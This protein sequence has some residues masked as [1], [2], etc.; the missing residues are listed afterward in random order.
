MR[1]VQYLIIDSDFVQGTNNN[2]VVTFGITSNTFIQEMKDVVAIKLVD[3]YVTQV[4]V[5]GSGGHG[6]GA[7]YIDI[8]CKDIPTA[9]QMLSE[10]T[11]EVFARVPLERDSDGGANYLV[12]DKEWKPYTND[13]RYFN[14][15][16]IKSLHFQMFEYQGDGDYLPLHPGAEFYMVLELT[17]IDHKAPPEDKLVTV[18][19]NLE[20]I[21]EKLDNMTRLMLLPPPEPPQKKYPVKYLVLIVVL[22]ALLV[23]FIRRSYRTSSVPGQ[24]RPGL[25]V[26]VRPGM[27]AGPQGPAPA[28]ALAP[29]VPLG[30]RV[31][32]PLGS[33]FAM[34][35]RGL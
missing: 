9:G 19:E 3:F 1:K 16:S 4:G 21:S 31:G 30:T 5:G 2:F 14:P 17:T 15:M 11:S 12:H 23:Y 10:R 22:V 29:G 35:P 27:G 34:R 24:V 13:T 7:K 8:V 33:E 25:Q 26:P 28:P 20:S 18:I 6:D 32:P